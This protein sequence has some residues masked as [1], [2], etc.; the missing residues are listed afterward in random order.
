MVADKVDLMHGIEQL[1]DARPDY[2]LAEN[3]YRGTVPE[4]FASSRLRAA[5]AATGIDF[6]LNFAKTPVDAV[7]N[8]L[9]ISAVTSANEDHNQIISQVWD[10]NAL[11]LEIPDLHRKTDYFGDA[12]LIV[13]PIEDDQENITGVEIHYNSPLTVR[14]IYSEEN[15]REI[16]YVIKRWAQRT[17]LGLVQRAELYYADR[18]ERWTT[19]PGAKGAQAGDWIHWTATPEDGEEPDEDS[20]TIP[21]D[22]GRPPVFHFR[23]DRPYGEP[24]HYGA[25]GPQ[26]AINKLA[27][28]HMG[29]VDYQ[30]APQR[31]ALTDAATTDTS[32]LEPGDWDDFPQDDNA[33]GPTD[34]GDDSSL[35][36]GAGEVWLLRGFKSVGQFD[37]AK[38]ETFLDPITFYIRAMAQITKTP[39]SMFDTQT[40]QEISG[41]SRRQKEAEFV[42]KIRH[43]QRLFGA[44]HRA[45]WVFILGLLGIPD[46]IVDIRWAPIATVEDKTGWE[47]NGLKVRN[48]VPRRQVLLES[49]YREEQVDEWLEGVDDAE[50]ARRVDILAT[51]ADSAQKLGAAAAL[52]VV[53]SEQ[54]QALLTGALSDIELLAGVEA[55][56]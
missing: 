8:R 30:G 27:I 22:W 7:V 1:D 28:T 17:S 31:Y 54:V 35:K 56:T 18:I 12:Y 52:G 34:S 46:A 42:H 45:M 13:L 33:T 3:M 25:Y 23:T 48:G 39:L 11:D 41:E 37:A 21:H 49:G 47:T 10:T 36:A 15:P 43:R 5:L 55:T 26:N 24:E 20:W 50:L 16:D 6:D 51:V 9:E 44:E 53:T 19:K 4:V 40:G 14:A 38:P 32:D 2:R 29:T